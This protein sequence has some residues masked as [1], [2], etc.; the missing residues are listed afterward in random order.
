VDKA[1]AFCY[2]EVLQGFVLALL[3]NIK[4]GCK[5]LPFKNAPAYKIAALITT[6]K[7]F[8]VQTAEKLC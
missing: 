8:I 2:G 5:W 4:L 1:K 7:S 3:G 6:V